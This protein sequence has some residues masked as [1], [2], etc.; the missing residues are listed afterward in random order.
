MW[1]KVKF[2]TVDFYSYFAIHVQVP[3]MQEKTRVAVRDEEIL[4]SGDNE[5]ILS[6]FVACG[7]EQYTG[8]K[9]ASGT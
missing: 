3:I 4:R 7:L 8:E 9:L 1:E 2:K 6:I 5:T